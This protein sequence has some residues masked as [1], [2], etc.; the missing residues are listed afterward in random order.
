VFQFLLKISEQ[1]AH[2][3][4]QLTLTGYVH[5]VLNTDNMNITGE[6]FDFGP[7]RFLPRFNPCFTAAY[8]DHQGLYSYGRQ[9]ESLLWGLEQLGLALR[10]LEPQ[11][12]I[13]GALAFFIEK[14]HHFQKQHFFQRL[15]LQPRG[16]SKDEALMTAFF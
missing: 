15:L 7:Y 10:L 13:E 8:F 5:A 12:N 6:V 3:S 14:F 1:T 11:L 9:P 2:L 4:S 16:D